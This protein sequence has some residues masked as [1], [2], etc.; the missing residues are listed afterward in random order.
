MNVNDP[1][2]LVVVSIGLASSILLYLSAIPLVRKIIAAKSVLYYRPDSFIIGIIYS[3]AKAPYPIINF[4]IGPLI[5]S[6]AS[7]ILYSAYW[8]I[9]MYYTRDRKQRNHTIRITGISLGILGIILCAG[10]LVFWVVKISGQ[11]GFEWIESQGG[12]MSLIE[13]FFGV[14]STV[15]VVLLMSS[16]LTSVKQVIVENDSRSISGWMLAGNIFCATCWSCYSFLIMN[17]YFIAANVVGDTA[18]LVQLGVK[19]WYYR[20]RQAEKLPEAKP[21]A[22]KPEEPQI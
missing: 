16:Q 21:E 18:C 12:Y 22:A 9:Y 14:C 6:G 10:P 7:L 15:S 17:P 11:G 4:Q 13:I 8:S 3:I 5:S 2:P 19:V 20:G 1:I